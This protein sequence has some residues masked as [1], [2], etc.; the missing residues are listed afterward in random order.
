MLLLAMKSPWGSSDIIFCS[1]PKNW[2]TENFSVFFLNL[3]KGPF[4]GLVLKVIFKH[5]LAI[6]HKIVPHKYQ[7][8][9]SKVRFVL[10][11]VIPLFV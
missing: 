3:P 8:I 5:F 10:E 9:L 2:C 6:K 7:E 11:F 1:Y 4:G